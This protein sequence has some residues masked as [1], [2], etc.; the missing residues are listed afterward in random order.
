MVAKQK[1][2]LLE[3]FRKIVEDVEQDVTLVHPFDGPTL[4]EVLV[5]LERIQTRV[6]E[7]GRIIAD[8]NV[9]TI[10]PRT[11]G[12]ALHEWWLNKAEAEVTPLIAKAKEYG[13]TRRALD[14]IEIGRALMLAGVEID[15]SADIYQATEA[16]LQELGIYFYLQGKF[17]RWTA[18]IA[19]GRPVSA[20]TLL[21]IG[22]YV[23][24][25]QRIREQGGWP[26]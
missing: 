2:S 22:I 20:D 9:I 6:T 24:M 19:E 26:V 18:A 3:R 23:R 4:R 1:P 15:Q 21:D 8:T 12:S 13:G 16:E 7:D 11:E 25:V 17:A 10:D 14:L 5:L